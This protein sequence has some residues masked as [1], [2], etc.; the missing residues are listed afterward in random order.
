VLPNQIDRVSVASSP[1]G[2]KIGE[3][4]ILLSRFADVIVL[5]E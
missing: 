1:D 5:I 4:G 3:M 2:L